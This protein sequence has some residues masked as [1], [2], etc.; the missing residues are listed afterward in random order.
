MYRISKGRV[1]RWAVPRYQAAVLF[2]ETTIVV[3][4]THKKKE[5]HGEER[6]EKMEPNDISKGTEGRAG[7]RR[8]WISGSTQ[9]LVTKGC[10]PFATTINS[11]NGALIM[12]LRR[13]EVV[14]WNWVGLF[15]PLRFSLLTS[16][17]PDLLS[18]F[19][20]CPKY[21]SRIS[22]SDGV[23]AEIWI[24]LETEAQMKFC[25]ISKSPQKKGKVT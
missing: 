7:R 10:S 14:Y 23:S 8:G 18:F 19:T 6:E 21:V 22:L 25:K 16:S 11:G 4:C 3:T 5:R 20:L 15:F 2:T 12:K 1:K 17:S 24:R 9:T 13:C